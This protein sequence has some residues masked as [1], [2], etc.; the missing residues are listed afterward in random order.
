MVD[1]K[2]DLP[3]GM[4]YK[5]CFMVVEGSTQKNVAEA[6]LQGRK[7]K[8]SYDAGLE[9]I[10]KA[11]GKEKRLM[12]T[13]T[14]KK[15][16]YVIGDEVSSFFY[17]TEEF[18]EKCK[19]FL[20]VYVYM[21]HRVSETHGFALVE[22][23]KL[24]RLFCYDENEIQN[25]GEPLPVEEELEYRLPSDFEEA[26]DEDFTQVNE[27]MIMELAL[28]Q[29]GID[30]EKY[31]YKDVKLGKRFEYSCEVSVN[32]DPYPGEDREIT[33]AIWNL[34]EVRRFMDSTSVD[35]RIQLVEELKDSLTHPIV[36]AFGEIV[37]EFPSYNRLSDRIDELDCRLRTMKTYRAAY[38]EETVLSKEEF[39]E[40]IN[41]GIYTFEGF[42]F[43]HFAMEKIECDTLTFKDCRFL[44]MK[45]IHNQIKHLKCVDCRFVKAEI[46]GKI[47]NANIILD[48]VEFSHCRIYDLEIKGEV[49]NTEWKNCY[50]NHCVYESVKICMDISFIQGSHWNC[51][52]KQLELVIRKIVDSSI[53]G[54]KFETVRI[55]ADVTDNRLWN[56]EIQGLEKMD[57]GREADWSSNSFR[58]CMINGE[59]K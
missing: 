45:L 9:K 8:Y 30:V 57:I 11:T 15:Q 33:E 48:H 32:P 27:D 5:S 37:D 38:C 41:N 52:A 19:S 42:T 53:D 34:P 4:G 47:E 21:T 13:G 17:D 18:L 55:G 40:K 50:F 43:K 58:N 23:G 46:C 51:K 14:Y 12:V 29:V 25:I 35:Q 49:Q 1:V 28:A 59:E 39:F 2:R 22:N 7:M 3:R 31:P 26:R 36:D 44:D 56:V 24:V 10:H 6:F 54:G 20:R 16:N